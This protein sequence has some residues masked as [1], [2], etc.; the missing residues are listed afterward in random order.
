MSDP[1]ATRV[2]Q[3]HAVFRVLPGGLQ[4]H[5]TPSQMELALFS[6]GPRFGVITDEELHCSGYGRQ[7][8]S[9]APL[10][11]GHGAA[12]LSSTSAAI[13]QLYSERPVTVTHAGLLH[14]HGSM[15]AHVRLLEPCEVLDTVQLEFAAG[16]LRLAFPHQPQVPCRRT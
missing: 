14:R 9:V 7:E 10:S 5:E 11:E 2:V 6:R 4:P 8:L 1:A 3:R 15:I 12:T 16:Q 13:F